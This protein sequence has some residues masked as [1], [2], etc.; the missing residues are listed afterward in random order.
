MCLHIAHCALNRK[1]MC[2]F[3]IDKIIC[4]CAYLRAF[5]L[6]DKEARR[7]PIKSIRNEMHAVW[8]NVYF[9]IANEW[10]QSDLV[11][12]EKCVCTLL[13]IPLPCQR[14]FTFLNLT[15]GEKNND[16][17]GSSL[18]NSNCDRSRTTAVAV[19]FFHTIFRA[20]TFIPAKKNVANRVT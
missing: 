20:H 7:I 11:Q 17:S 19:V 15:E 18:C 12:F 9:S 8:F 10:K 2:D 1:W 4:A 6:H 14:R 5:C 16:N 3:G 13:A